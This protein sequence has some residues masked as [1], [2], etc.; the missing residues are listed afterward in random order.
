MGV[1]WGYLVVILGLSLGY[2]GLSF[3][4]LGVTWGN[5]GCIFGISLGC[6]GD[7]LLISAGQENCLHQ[8]NS[9]DADGDQ[10]E[11]KHSARAA[12]VSDGTTF[13]QVFSKDESIWI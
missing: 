12:V 2:L 3:G 8:E 10:N 5:L 13:E 4:Y 1:S 6:L 11:E 7:I 9:F